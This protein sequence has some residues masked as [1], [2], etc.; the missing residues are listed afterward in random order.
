MPFNINLSD[1][2]AEATVGG[3]QDAA[4]TGLLHF[5]AI[6][7]VAVKVEV[8]LVEF[9]AEHRGAAMDDLPFQVVLDGV[10]VGVEDD[11]VEG[12]DE[13]GHSHVEVAEE[14]VGFDTGVDEVLSPFEVGGGCLQLNHGAH[15][16]GAVGIAAFHT[17]QRVLG[18]F[19]LEGEDGLC[20][21]SGALGI[22]ADQLEHVRHMLNIFVAHLLRLLGDVVV[23]VGKAQA[24]LIEVH[25]DHLG[26]FRVG[27][28][29][30]AKETSETFVVQFAQQFAEVGLVGQAVYHFEIGEE[31]GIA[32]RVDGHGVH[33]GVVKVADFLGYA[34]VSGSGVGR[35][36]FDNVLDEQL[37]VLV[38]FGKRAERGVFLGYR[39]VFQ[40]VVVA[41]TEKVFRRI[42]FQIH[43]FLVDGWGILFLGGSASASNHGSC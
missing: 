37:I 24:A 2:F 20:F 36:L 9:A 15:V 42:D 26:V 19:G 29:T 27:G 38:D 12:T 25:N 33:A 13:V 8:L 39:V 1:G 18:Q 7:V 3:V 30:G 34:A 14:L 5:L 31:L 11:A 10:E 22:N 17:A 35:H 41:I 32:A 43:V 4:P 28:W 16:V 23:A 21:G 6:E 40:P